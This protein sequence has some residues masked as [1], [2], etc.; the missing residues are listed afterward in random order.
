MAVMSTLARALARSR[1][2]TLRHITALLRSC[3]LTLSFVLALSHSRSLALYSAPS[4]VPLRSVSCPL[5]VSL[6]P[7]AAH[8]LPPV[9]RAGAVG[10][11]EVVLI[12]MLVV[13]A[14]LGAVEAPA[15]SALGLRP[16]L[17][18][19]I[20]LLLLL[21]TQCCTHPHRCLL[22]TLRQLFMIP[23]LVR[24]GWLSPH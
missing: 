24:G 15:G 11:A 10:K 12:L 20:M 16:R 5:P 22:R 23:Q 21:H 19:M 1:S 2:L 7:R 17:V 3:S 8:S 14:K 6:P 9:R 13:V 18:T 4:R